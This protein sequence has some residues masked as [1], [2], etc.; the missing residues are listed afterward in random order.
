MHYFFKVTFPD[1]GDEI[2]FELKLRDS[3]SSKRAIVET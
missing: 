1:T 2:H 3:V